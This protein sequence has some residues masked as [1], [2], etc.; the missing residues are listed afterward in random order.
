MYMDGTN[1]R[2]VCIRSARRIRQNSK[3]IVDGHDLLGYGFSE[4]T[5]VYDISSTGISFYM[6]NRPW[7]EDSLQIT[8]YPD[9]IQDTAYLAGR[10]S[11]GRVVRTGVILDDKQFVAARFE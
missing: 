9:E 7:I 5:Q 6:K 2:T 10:K 11:R 3:L 1:S 4:S 8:I